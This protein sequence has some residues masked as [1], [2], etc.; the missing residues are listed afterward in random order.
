MNSWIIEGIEEMKRVCEICGKEYEPYYA[1]VNKQVICGDPEC[2]RKYKEKYWKTHSR[3]A[4]LEKKKREI[5]AIG[6]ARC[7]ICGEL[8]RRPQSYSERAASTRFHEDC[9]LKDCAL[10]YMA[11]GKLTNIQKQRLYAR[12]YNLRE[13]YS[14]TDNIITDHL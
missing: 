6:T 8:I 7:R 13:F 11:T 9:I 12:G 1:A 5:R 10:T 14:N 2:K 4:W 3:R